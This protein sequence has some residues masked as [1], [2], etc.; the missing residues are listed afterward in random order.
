MNTLEPAL[1]ARGLVKRYPDVL[2]V[3]GVDLEVRRGE[4]FGILGPNGAGKTT[5]VEI[6]EG[7]TPVDDG[8]IEVLGRRWGAGRDRELRQRLGVQLQETQLGEKLTVHETV[9]LFRSFYAQGR[10]PE[11][12]LAMTGLQEKRNGRVGRLSGG[13]KQRLALACALVSNPELLFLDEP[14]TG[15]DPQARLKVWE[16]VAE[17]RAA[18]GTV[19]LTTHYMEEAAHLCDRV[20]IM[21]HG[22]IIALDTPDALITSLGASQLV[23]FTAATALPEEVLL[24]LPGVAGC[25]ARNGRQVL[26]VER[27]GLALPA[28]LAELHQ[29]GVELDSLQTRQATLEDVFIRLT[30]RALRDEQ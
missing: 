12:V 17:F 4:C 11:T 27:M 23:E 13:Q 20:A 21:D 7:L 6:L 24:E 14:T 25:G 19:V 22:R 30:G 18:G 10:D 8:D 29:R 2:A 9:R 15:L 28:L 3:A 1:A 5:T 26:H 16:I